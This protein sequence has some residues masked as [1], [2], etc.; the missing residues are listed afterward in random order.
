MFDLLIHAAR[1]NLDKVFHQC[2][3]VFATRPQRWQRNREHIQTVVEV[4]AKFAPL[5]HINQISVG[6]SYQANVHLV[7]PSAA[8]TLELLF[9]QDTQ[10]FG[11]QSRRN[12]S[13]LVQEKRPLVSQFE[14]ANLLRNSASKS[15]SLMAKKLAFQ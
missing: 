4:A 7:S 10:Q 13:H 12:I 8:Q 15:A 6:R 3:N 2:R 5:H 14:T 11:L 1:I 9:L